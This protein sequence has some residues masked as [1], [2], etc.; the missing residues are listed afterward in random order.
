MSCISWCLCRW[1]VQCNM[2]NFRSSLQTRGKST[3]WTFTMDSV[4]ASSEIVPCT[5]TM[6]E[7]HGW[8][9]LDVVQ[10]RFLYFLKKLHFINLVAKIKMSLFNDS[11]FSAFEKVFVHNCHWLFIHDILIKK[12]TFYAER[13]III[14]IW[15]ISFKLFNIDDFKASGIDMKE[16]IVL[17]LTN[18]HMM[19][20]PSI[21]DT[22]V[23]HVLFI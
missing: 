9:G 10:C 14:I 3:K 5:I 21:S 4:V 15:L 17:V 2:C 19:I 16:Y 20:I 6:L 13:F 18:C 11:S 8:I 23:F 1:C 12:I 7:I 22:F